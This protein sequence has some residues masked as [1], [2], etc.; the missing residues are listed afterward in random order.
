MKI[1]LQATKT[2]GFIVSVSAGKQWVSDIAKGAQWNK[3]NWP[4]VVQSTLIAV[5]SGTESSRKIN[6]IT[7]T[8]VSIYSNLA[9]GDIEGVCII[10]IGKI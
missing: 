8:G 10:A 4:I 7:N 6:F 9:A 1:H 3:Y 5:A 2:H